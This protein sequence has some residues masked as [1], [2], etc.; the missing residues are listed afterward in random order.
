MTLDTLWANVPELVVLDPERCALLPNSSVLCRC[1]HFKCVEQIAPVL[2]RIL[3]PVDV[4]DYAASALLF[5]YFAD[6]SYVLYY[7][8]TYFELF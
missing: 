7:T 5:T 6:I 4:L 8:L 3:P 2:N 1:P